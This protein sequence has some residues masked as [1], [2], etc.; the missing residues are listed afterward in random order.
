MRRTLMALLALLLVSLS[1]S[2][3]SVSKEALLKDIVRNVIVPDYQ[4]LTSK[5]QALTVE[6]EQLSRA[7][8]TAAAEKARQAWLTARLA[9]RRIQWLQS[10]PIADREFLA[11]FY[12]ARVLPV[13]IE[14]VLNATRAIDDSFLDELGASAKGM[15]TLEYLLFDGRTDMSAKDPKNPQA[16]SKT[17]F[18]TNT[19]RHCEYLVALVK[20][21]Q[22]KAALVTA[23]WTDTNRNAAANKFVGGGQTT[24]NRLVN[25]LAGILETVAENHLNY[26]LQLPT[27]ITEQ[28]DRIEGA[29][30][31]TSLAQLAAILR[32]AHKIYRAGEGVGVDDYLRGLNQP[33]ELRVESQFQKAFAALQ[34][35]GVPLDVAVTDRKESVQRAYQAVRDLEIL[36]KVD[37]AS[38]LGVTI[39]I[40]S[41]DGD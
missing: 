24:L 33:L 38:A 2:A 7:P 16:D 19:Q 6:L 40:N 30:S 29:R 4:E 15:F 3:Q 36:F 18:G 28:R 35:I 31:R 13:R 20:D 41:N 17:P 32:G 22:R 39:T 14:G 9:S 11:A 34:D 8:T 37:V 10:G 27:P 23:D 12:Y 1:A 26:A 25:E 5:C 21:L